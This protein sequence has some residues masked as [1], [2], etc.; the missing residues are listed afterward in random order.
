MIDSKI[1]LND[2]EGSVRRLARKGVDV[3]SLTELRDLLEQRRSA[4]HA[5]NEARADLNKTSEEIGKLARTGAKEEVEAKRGGVLRLKEKIAELEAQ[6]RDVQE[7][8]DYILLRTPNFPADDAPDGASEADNV[9][10]RTHGYDPEQYKG[11][12]VSPALGC[13]EC[14]RNLRRRARR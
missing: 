7:K 9:V 2:F 3:Q 14:A 10:V 1:I 4:T 13:R 5:L 8:A 12:D 11:K 6:E